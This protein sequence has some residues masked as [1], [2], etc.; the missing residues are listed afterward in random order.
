MALSINRLI[1]WNLILEFIYV[2][3]LQLLIEIASAVISSKAPN[4]SMTISRLFLYK[5]L[6]YSI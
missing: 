4:F 3:Y 6:N 2:E 5:E 1:T